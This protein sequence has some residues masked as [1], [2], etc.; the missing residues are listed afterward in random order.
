[1]IVFFI[2]SR[3]I[4][5]F[6]IV[7][8]EKRY[9]APRAARPCPKPVQIRGPFGTHLRHP[10]FSPFKPYMVKKEFHK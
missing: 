3:I 6:I 10:F 1:M 4:Q 9:C 8:G 2:I 5:A 7:W